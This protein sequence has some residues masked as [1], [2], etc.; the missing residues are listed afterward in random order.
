MKT[1]SPSHSLDL[2]SHSAAAIVRQ[3][4]SEN[5]NIRRCLATAALVLALQGTSS[6]Q[7]PL[8]MN[9]QGRVDVGGVNFDG[10]GQFRFA[11]VDQ[12]TNTSLQA[13]ATA[14]VTSGF[15]TS[16]VVTDGG[17]GYTSAPTASF[18]K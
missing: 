5:H 15:V 1:T 16:I 10:T 12:G 2:S 7:V 9:Y 14:T 4:V 18:M 11:I 13:T 17:S 3:R 8:I 6:S